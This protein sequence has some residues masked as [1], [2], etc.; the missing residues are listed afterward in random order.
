MPM[1]QSDR[2]TLFSGSAIFFALNLRAFM[3]NQLTN[4]PQQTIA[5]LQ[6][7]LE[8]M[9]K[10]LEQSERMSTVGTLASSI[11]H[12]FNNILMTVINYAKM[13]TRHK[14]E[15]TRDKAFDK[16]LAAGQRAAKITTGMLAYA[17]GKEGHRDRISLAQLVN[18]V[19]VLVEKD[20]QVHRIQLDLN[21]DPAVEANVDAIAVQQVMMNLIINARQAMSEGGTLSIG[22]KLTEQKWAE[23]TVKDTGVG[24]PAEK[25]PH[26]FERFYTT[27]KVDQQGQGGTGLG[28]SH[29]KDVMV[30]HQGKVKVQSQPNNGTLF[31]LQFPIETP[32]LIETSKK[33]A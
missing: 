15:A 26:I 17:R 5:D 23:L 1:K 22:V 12:E 31:V 3:T 4:D 8:Q 30:S 2:F 7:Q 10:Q 21:L 6:Q 13:G 32:G 25:L 19:L 16:I 20:L 29:C 18:D 14:E 27:K 9:Q 28:L 24:I 11:T 33:S